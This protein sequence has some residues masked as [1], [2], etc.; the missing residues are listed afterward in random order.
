MSIIERLAEFLGAACGLVM[1]CVDWLIGK[2]R[3]WREGRKP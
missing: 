1:R 2:R 3:T